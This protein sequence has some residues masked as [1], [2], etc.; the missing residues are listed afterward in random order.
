MIQASRRNC[1]Y[2]SLVLPA[3]L[4]LA[5]R[6]HAEKLTIASTP[7]G[8]TL[9]ID[10]AVV[11]TTPYDIAYPGGYFH[12]THTVFGTRL[13]H[14][15]LLYVY[16]D[17][18]APQKVALTSGPFDW[19]AVTGRH[20]GKYF[21]LKSERFD[22]ALEPAASSSKGATEANPRA[23]PMHPHPAVS[24]LLNDAAAPSDSGTVEIDSDPPHA[25]IYVDW[26]FAGQTPSTIHLASG[27]HHVELKSRGRQNWERELEVAKGSEITLRPVLE[28]LPPNPTDH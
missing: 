13:E 23:G 5:A 26:K 2:A 7:P 6:A 4:L 14:A 3:M 20:H 18:Y 12:K 15:M 19:V 24:A 8:A 11:G 17:G 27:P 16:K 21:L 10:G 28:G 22:I 1:P 9:E 25:E